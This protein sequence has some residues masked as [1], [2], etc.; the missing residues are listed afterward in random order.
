MHT[1]IQI[2]IYVSIHIYIYIHIHIYIYIYIHIHAD[3]GVLVRMAADEDSS[4]EDSSDEEAEDSWALP[5]EA[6]APVSSAAP[7]EPKEPPSEA[8]RLRARLLSNRAA[9]AATDP[10][11]ATGPATEGEKTR[12]P[13]RDGDRKRRHR[14]HRRKSKEKNVAALAPDAGAASALLGKTSPGPG[15]SAV[16]VLPPQ[17]L[18]RRTAKRRPT[19]TP[20]TALSAGEKSEAARQGSTCIVAQRPTWPCRSGGTAAAHGKPVR[21]KPRSRLL[22]NGASDARKKHRRRGGPCPSGGTRTRGT[23]PTAVTKGRF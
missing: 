22:Q 2:S 19:R 23:R 11:L 17:S 7:P 9:R 16:R 5:S 21:R 1:H 10:R 13:E 8:A 4:S 12:S 18:L 14:E 3:A 20:T 15:P 6:A